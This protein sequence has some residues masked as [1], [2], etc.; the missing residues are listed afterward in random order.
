MYGQP[1]KYS[2]LIYLFTINSNNFLVF[3]TLLQQI[4]ASDDSERIWK[5]EVVA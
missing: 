1:V 2:K 5:E 3:Q 4:T